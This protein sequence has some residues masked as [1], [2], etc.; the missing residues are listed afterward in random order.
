MAGLLVDVGITRINTNLANLL[1]NF[2]TPMENR[3][4]LFKNNHTPVYAD[5]LADFD[6]CTFPGYGDSAIGLPAID[7]SFPATHIDVQQ[8]E[9]NTFTRTSGAG[10]ETVYGYLCFDTSDDTLLWAEL[11]PVP[12]LIDTDGQS[13][14]IIPTF[15]LMDRSTP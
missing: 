7:T 13:V 5:T 4:R 3:I 10:S 1:G 9:P 15:S 6:V 11:L 12:I 14:I 8:F 2:A